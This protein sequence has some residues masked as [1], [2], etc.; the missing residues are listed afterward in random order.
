MINAKILYLGKTNPNYNY[1]INQVLE[2]TV[3][4]K[5]LGINVDSLLNFSDHITMTVKKSR[6]I[7]AMLVR[8]ISFKEID[9]MVT[10]F[11]SLV[12]PILEYGMWYGVRLGLKISKLS[13]RYK[14][15][16][17]DT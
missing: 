5:D 15:T 4:E 9:I 6:S 14:G 10:L 3:C 11:T 8:N 16:L 17:P 1:S 2:V 12:R 13:R 7:A